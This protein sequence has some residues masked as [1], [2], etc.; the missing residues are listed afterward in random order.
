VTDKI[1]VPGIQLLHEKPTL[2]VA[3]VIA[4]IL[5]SRQNIV[6]LTY[7]LGSHFEVTCKT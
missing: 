5:K 4:T 7:V 1:V 3:E 6:K 2:E